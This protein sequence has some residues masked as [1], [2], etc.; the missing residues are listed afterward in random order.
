MKFVVY[1]DNPV[2]SLGITYMTMDSTASTITDTDYV[3]VTLDTFYMNGLM[4]DTVKVAING[5]NKVELAEL[6]KVKLLD[7]LPGDRPVNFADSVA[8]G[9]IMNDDT[10]K[11]VIQDASVAKGNGPTDTLKFSVTT[12]QLADSIGIVYTTMDSTA[13]AGSD[14]FSQSDTIYLNNSLVDTIRITAIVSTKLLFK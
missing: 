11:I 10:A 1:V 7:I 3:A 8:I 12:S 2:D 6:L 9:T 14:Y 4:T 5:E 13:V